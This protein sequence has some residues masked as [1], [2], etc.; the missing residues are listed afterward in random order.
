MRLRHAPHFNIL[1]LAALN[2]H[3]RP[4]SKYELS[5]RSLL[6]HVPA[7]STC[8]NPPPV[9]SSLFLE[10][11]GGR[12]IRCPLILSD[13]LASTGL[14]LGEGAWVWSLVR[15]FASPSLPPQFHSLPPSRS[16]AV[17]R[18]SEGVDCHVLP[19]LPASLSQSHTCTHTFSHTHVCTHVLTLFLSMPRVF[20]AALYAI[21]RCTSVQAPFL[22]LLCCCGHYFLATF[23]FFLHLSLSLSLSHTLLCIPKVSFEVK[24]GELMAL[25]SSE[26][27]FPT[28]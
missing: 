5:A 26:I 25:A 20:R 14:I 7:S 6:C 21:K 27:F 1:S 19:S 11:G 28:L 8:N 17:S 9:P 13:S 4:Y 12:G 18:M 23:S 24:R 10:R 3:L 16:I 2:A 15:L 22:L